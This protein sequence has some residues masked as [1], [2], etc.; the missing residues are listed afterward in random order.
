MKLHNSKL[1][2]NQLPK[3]AHMS[4]GSMHT[5]WSLI[6]PT[7]LAFALLWYNM[8]WNYFN[9]KRALVAMQRNC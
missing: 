2:W 7:V 6:S 9:S 3:G 4:L 1:L 5:T 8:F